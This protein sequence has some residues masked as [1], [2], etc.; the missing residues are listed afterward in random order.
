MGCSCQDQARS[1]EASLV[2]AASLPRRGFADQLHEVFVVARQGF[3]RFCRYA[4]GSG[5]GGLGV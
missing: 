3:R 1:S 5:Y 2:G 4:E